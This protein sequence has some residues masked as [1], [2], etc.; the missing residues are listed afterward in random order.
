MMSSNQ[1]YFQINA[2]VA[3]KLH[4]KFGVDRTVSEFPTIFFKQ[5]PLSRAAAVTSSSVM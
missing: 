4:T 3:R 2:M 5:K 1:V